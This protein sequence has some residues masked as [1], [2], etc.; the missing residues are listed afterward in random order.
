MGNSSRG[1]EFPLGKGILYFIHNCLRFTHNTRFTHHWR[2]P[3]LTYSGWVCENKSLS[4]NAFIDAVDVTISLSDNAD[5][6][7]SR[8]DDAADVTISVSDDSV[9]VT[10]YQDDNAVDVTIQFSGPFYSPV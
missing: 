10:I 1:R 6:T 9:D 7:I 3:A 5:V 8:A 2:R 4:D